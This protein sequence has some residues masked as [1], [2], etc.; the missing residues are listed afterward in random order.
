VPTDS[1][2]YNGGRVTG[3][4]AAG[5]QGI[6]EI[7]GG[8]G[9]GGGGLAACGTG[10][11]CPAGV[12]S[13]AGGL[14]LAGYGYG[15]LKTASESLGTDFTNLFAQE[16]EGTGS[17]GTGDQAGGGNNGGEGVSAADATRL[18]AK[19]G[20]EEAG[21][22]TKEG[23]LTNE[24]V[25]G[26]QEIPISGG[27]LTNPA[28]VNELTANGSRIEDWGKF[29]TQSIE[30][31]GGQASQIHFYRNR[32]TGQVNLNIDFKIKGTVK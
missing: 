27:R 23:I 20:F 6:G 22:L 5:L 29:R 21:I 9:L 19:L 17:V 15:T 11:L 4:L 7:V 32:V 31:P 10:V 8:S 14:V 26:A 24:A 1:L 18:K 25:A 28:V 2:F 30:L 16:N 3:D 12:P 13:I